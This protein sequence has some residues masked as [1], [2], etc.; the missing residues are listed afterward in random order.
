MHVKDVVVF[1]REM[2]ERW[3]SKVRSFNGQD[4]DGKGKNEFKAERMRKG[5]TD[6]GRCAMMLSAESKLV[7]PT[8]Q[9]YHGLIAEP[10]WHGQS[11]QID[12]QIEKTC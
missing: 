3:R 10:L 4:L 11:V 5:N 8:A 7:Q 12:L 2:N 6:F 1:R 9:Q